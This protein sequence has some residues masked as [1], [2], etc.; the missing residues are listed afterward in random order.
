MS[1][2]HRAY[3]NKSCPDEKSGLEKIKINPVRRGELDKN[4]NMFYRNILKQAWQVT[5][6]YKFLWL[7]GLLA[8][9]WSTGSAYEIIYRS[10]SLSD[11]KEIF[12]IQIWRETVLAGLDWTTLKYF[13]TTSPMV[14]AGLII[15]MLLAILITIFF[16]WLFTCGQVALIKAVDVIETKKTTFHDLFLDSHYQAWPVFV[17]NLGGK[18]LSAGLLLILSYPILNPLL[19]NQSSFAN[20]FIYLIAFILLF[21]LIMIVSIVTIYSIIYVVLE[22]KSLGSAISNAWELF[23]KNWLV[24]VETSLLLFL[25][26]LAAL[27]LF[28]V[29]STLA[30]IPFTILFAIVA[31]FKSLFGFW[32]LVVIIALFIIAILILSF[33]LLATFQWSVW[34][35]LFEE[36]VS[37]RATSKL[38]RIGSKTL[39]LK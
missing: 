27:F 31:Y 36:M 23:R 10:L 21:A 20:L 38:E 35:T 5:W 34:I 30:F 17:L 39:G 8:G 7:F 28:L 22:K 26:V 14:F 18:I 11:Q 37:G 2:T 12:L 33:A 9:F 15:G 25:V 19:S 1:P 29:F 3:L 4:Q 24:S 32:F 16:Y 6:R 13:A